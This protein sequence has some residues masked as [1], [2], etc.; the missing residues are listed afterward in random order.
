MTPVPPDS[1]L[2]LIKQL[3]QFYTHTLSPQRSLLELLHEEKAGGTPRNLSKQLM[4]HWPW[5]LNKI[6]LTAPSLGQREAFGFPLGNNPPSVVQSEATSWTEMSKRSGSLKC[7]ATA[8][9]SSGPHVLTP[10]LWPHWGQ[11][12]ALGTWVP[13][14]QMGRIDTARVQVPLTSAPEGYSLGSDWPSGA[15]C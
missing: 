1:S 8:P 10:A 4:W 11:E 15:L 5:W 9:S 2:V 13:S 6:V 12:K 3:W 7:S 14:A